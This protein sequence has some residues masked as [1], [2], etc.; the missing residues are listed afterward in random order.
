MTRS[1]LA[2]AAAK[3]DP[4]AYDYTL[5]LSRPSWVWEFLRRD[6]NFQDAARS[7]QTQLKRARTPDR[8]FRHHV[9]FG[10]LWRDAGDDLDG[11]QR[12]T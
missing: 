10:L 5:K 11:R 4:T 12:G 8:L 6:P 9:G 2:Y 7:L 3:P 1:R